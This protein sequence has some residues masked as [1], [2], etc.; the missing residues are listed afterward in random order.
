MVVIILSG[1]SGS[2]KTTVLRSLGRQLTTQ[3]E[4]YMELNTHKVDNKHVLSKWTYIASWFDSV[5]THR[6]EGAT[7]LL[8]DRSPV[9]T[10]AYAIGA[11]RH[12]LPA[13]LESFHEL[14]YYGIRCKTILVT[15]AFDILMQ[16]IGARLQKE[17]HRAAYHEDS[18]EFC[19][20]AY[21]FY[22]RHSALWDATV[23]TSASNQERTV[24]DVRSVV[25]QWVD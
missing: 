10:A 12:I 15:A 6:S 5:L 13:V 1:P 24:R 20:Q 2:G 3:P 11:E 25:H 18:S 9:D 22:E 16:R 21:T 4:R 7:V 17:S 23:D 8:T 14:E 19:R